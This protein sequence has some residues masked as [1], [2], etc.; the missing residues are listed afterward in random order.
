MLQSASLAAAA[1]VLAPTHPRTAAAFAAH[2]PVSPDV[3]AAGLA[4]ARHADEALSLLAALLTEML[5]D[6]VSWD[7]PACLDALLAALQ[8]STLVPAAHAA[9][10]LRHASGE[11]CAAL[12]AARP[13]RSTVMWLLQAVST[14]P[15]LLRLVPWLI[16][17]RDGASA[18]ITP[19][20]EPSGL[21]EH[22]YAY[23]LGVRPP[24][25]RIVDELCL[26]PAPGAADAL[27]ALVAVAR[28]PDGVLDA[29]GS[30]PS[31][32]C[33][34]N[35]ML[36]AEMLANPY[37]SPTQRPAALRLATPSAIG[38]CCSTRESLAWFRRTVAPG[39]ASRTAAVLD[40]LTGHGPLF[41]ACLEEPGVLHAVAQVASP[42]S[43]RVLSLALA[44]HLPDDPGVFLTALMLAA[45]VD[46]SP[47]EIATLA[48]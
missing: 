12:I 20:P 1:G 47:A 34:A 4:N 13:T 40:E 33:T 36:V 3:L 41:H 24:S 15:A 19:S 10:A 7:S 44:P 30:Y 22:A 2:Q 23:A 8:G 18:V 46:A 45:S 29:T 9:S 31:A 32:P 17:L 35:V 28:N 43:R 5:A 6:P 26:K 27:V 16:A 21:G 14:T 42:T 25:R 39:P 48:S 37:L 38:T 11:L